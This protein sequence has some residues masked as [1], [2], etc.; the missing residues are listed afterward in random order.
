M[1]NPAEEIVTT[2]LQECKG[3]FIMNNIKVPKEKAAWD[4]KLIY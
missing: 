2:W 4:L 3:Y 1:K